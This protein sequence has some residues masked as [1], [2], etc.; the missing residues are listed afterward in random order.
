MLQLAF[1][2]PKGIQMLLEAGATVGGSPLIKYW[3]CPSPLLEDEIDFDGFFHSTK[4]LLQ[5]G[6]QLNVRDLQIAITPKLLSLFVHELAKRRWG[7][8][9]LGQAYLP[10]SELPKLDENIVPDIQASRLCATL[11]ANCKPIPTS[12]LVNAQYASVYHHLTLYPSVMEELFKIGFKQL[13]AP[14]TA[15]VTPLM[16]IYEGFS[17][18]WNIIARISW[19]V[20][21]GA[22]FHLKLPLSNAKAAHLIAVKITRALLDQL[23]LKKAEDINT[24]WSQWER[25]VSQHK[26][27]LFHPE[28]VDNCTCVC[29]PQGCTVA[30]VALRQ[31]LRWSRWLSVP[32]SS[33]WFR[34]LLQSLVGWTQ[35]STRTS[36]SI[37]RLLTFDGL[38]LKHTCCIEIDDEDKD[39]DQMRAR[40]EEEISEIQEENKPGI[41][42]LDSLMLEFEKKFDELGFPLIEFLEGYWHTRMVQH[43]LERDP[44]DEKH[45][46]ETRSIGVVLQADEG[47]LDRV[48]LF[49][50]A[51]VKE[52]DDDDING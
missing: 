44:Y 25:D 48:S 36:Q 43:V 31:A 18:Q 52:V 50:G 13:D 19:L 5:A 26:I 29:C 6:C 41:E 32:E 23:T 38:G 15:G 28:V 2:W 34:R 17:D 8:W 42:V 49:I 3:G 46:Q 14:D 1:G 40:D 33:L 51:Q 7:L 12:L 30:T 47:D 10:Q 24:R 9:K 11:A 45:D 37:I 4:L 20:S 21:K 35:Y 22:N 39:A 16:R 27:S